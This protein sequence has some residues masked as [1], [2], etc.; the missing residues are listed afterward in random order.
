MATL[1]STI[2]VWLHTSWP[3]KVVDGRVDTF[4][5]GLHVAVGPDNMLRRNDFKRGGGSIAASTHSRWVRDIW[6]SERSHWGLLMEEAPATLSGVPLVYRL[7]GIL[8]I[9][10]NREGAKDVLSCH[11]SCGRWVSVWAQKQ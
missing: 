2:Y 4:T 6:R 1:T 11:P 8:H 3:N 9:T 10:R 7:P 5:L